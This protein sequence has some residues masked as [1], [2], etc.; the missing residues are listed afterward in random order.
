MPRWSE[1][2]VLDDGTRAIVCFSGKRPRAPRC[3]CGAAAS[4]QCDFPILAGT[5][6]RYLCRRC[7]V[8]VGPDRDFCPDHL[9]ERNSH[10]D[11]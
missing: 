10:A 2:I 5:C 7:A 1:V 8:R 4:I 3:R 6:D 11:P 9:R